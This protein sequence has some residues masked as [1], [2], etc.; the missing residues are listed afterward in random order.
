MVYTV[1]ELYF[2]V[3]SAIIY[4]RFP[5][6][7]NLIN[8]LVLIAVERSVKSGRSKSNKSSF[9]AMSFRLSNNKSC[10]RRPDKRWSSI[11]VPLR[12]HIAIM[13]VPILIVINNNNIKATIGNRH[14]VVVVVVVTLKT[15][16][17]HSNPP[18]T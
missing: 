14:P 6:P 3:R 10:L 1:H 4:P 5:T 11:I 16:D 12:A 9:V 18:L 17:L 13:V 2:V 8:F 15:K 7:R